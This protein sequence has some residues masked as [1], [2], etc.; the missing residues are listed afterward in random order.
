M[1]GS[2]HF[3]AFIREITGSQNFESRGV[4]MSESR[5][6]RRK[7]SA[8]RVDGLEQRELLSANLTGS[9][10]DVPVAVD[11][12]F[13]IT[14][15]L[16][17]VGSATAIGKVNILFELSA[18]PN[19]RNAFEIGAITETVHLKPHKSVNVSLPVSLTGGSP[20]G[21]QYLVAIIQPGA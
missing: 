7:L 19:G 12:P 2:P 21:N 9:F 20:G 10:L 8:P 5:G 14:I 18:N 15:R 3:V 11:G 6:K 4:T 17:D 1:S 16:K 13:A